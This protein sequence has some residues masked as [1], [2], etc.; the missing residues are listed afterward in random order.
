L[1][2]HEPF[3]KEIKMSDAEKTM[4]AQAIEGSN[5][6]LSV[7]PLVEQV[8]EWLTLG[9]REYGAG[10]KAAEMAVALFDN[11]PAV[12]RHWILKSTRNGNKPAQQ[13]FAY[14]SDMIKTQA[15]RAGH[16]N[17]RKKLRDFLGYAKEVAGFNTEKKNGGGSTHYDHVATAMR[18]LRNHL[19]E[20]EG[21]SC[22]ELKNLWSAIEEAAL[23]DGVL[24]SED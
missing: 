23:N 17:P 7:S 14:I 6:K 2:P 13:A 20:T 11:D 15:E 22:L 1:C 5:G 12:K 18:S 16:S 4:I 21:N 3:K 19:L 8:S 10:R 24:K 9:K